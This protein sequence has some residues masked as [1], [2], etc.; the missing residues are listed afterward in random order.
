ML[1]FT[2]SDTA[3]SMVIC[4]LELNIVTIKLH[5]C[6]RRIYSNLNYV[7]FQQESGLKDNITIFLLY[8][9]VCGESYVHF[10]Y[11]NLERVRRKQIYLPSTWHVLPE[12]F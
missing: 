7:E 9:I 4:V 6:V 10:I 2:I 12:C 8:L 1:Q 11:F 3:C 5:G